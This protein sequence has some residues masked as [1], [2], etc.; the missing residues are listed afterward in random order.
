MAGR[1]IRIKAGS[2]EAAAEL[3]DTQTAESIWQAL[4]IKGTVQTW[5]DE[6]YFAIPLT[7]AQENAQDVVKIGDLGYWALGKA[8]CIFFGPTPASKGTE[9]RP[10]S[11]VNVFGRITGDATVFKMVEAGTEIALERGN[12]G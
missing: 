1:S 10:A 2:V 11:P 9:I 3:N 7:L 4:P 12:T 6:V 8:L 5:G